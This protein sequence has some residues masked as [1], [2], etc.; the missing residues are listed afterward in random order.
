[1][2]ALG[3]RLARLVRAKLSARSSEPKIQFEVD[4]APVRAPIDEE[5]DRPLR[6][7]ELEDGATREEIRAAYLRLSKRYHP[8]R[9]A[10]NKESERLAN[11]LMQELNRAYEGLM[12]RTD[13]KH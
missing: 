5:R 3:K 10:T 2:T 7:L 9:F 11:E 6:I 13:A 12:S 4:D 8:D 1:M